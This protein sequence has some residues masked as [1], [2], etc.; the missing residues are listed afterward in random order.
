MEVDWAWAV[1]AG[2]TGVYFTPAPGNTGLTPPEAQTKAILP[3]GSEVFPILE[4]ADEHN[5]LG[6]FGFVFDPPLPDGAVVHM[7]DRAFHTVS[8]SAQ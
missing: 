2:R 7:N 3:D 6:G 5:D 8:G 4:P 1:T